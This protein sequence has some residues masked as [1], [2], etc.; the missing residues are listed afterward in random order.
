MRNGARPSLTPR[1]RCCTQARDLGYPSAA[2]LAQLAA[3]PLLRRLELASAQVLRAHDSLAPRVRAAS[4]AGGARHGALG[5]GH[6]PD[7]VVRHILS[8]VPADARA[9]AALVCRGWRVTVSDPR[10]WTVLDLSPTSGVTCP[11]TDATL[12]GAAALARGGLTALCLDFHPALTDEARL[13]VVTAN[14]GSLRELSLSS[15]HGRA[16]EEAH[17]QELLGAAP[18][19]LSFKVVVEAPVTLAARMLRNEA[20]FGALQLSTLCVYDDEGN[21]NEA[22]LLSFCSAVPAQAPLRVLRFDALPLRA[23]V[24]NALSA[25]ALAHKLLELYVIQCDLSPASVPAL[26]RLIRGGVLKT[27]VIN[28][29]FNPLLD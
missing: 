29:A 12:R 6:L 1:P 26:A 8:Y 9:R 21:A 24:M 19:L 14:A 7:T 18:Q 22:A 2:V 28:N 17:V 11:V 13:E 20:P 27:L 10:L 23:A 16:V 4:D 25:A 15:W 5:F 3:A